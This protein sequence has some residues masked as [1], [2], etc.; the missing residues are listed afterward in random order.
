MKTTI[1]VIPDCPYCHQLKQLLTSANIEYE[2]IDIDTEAGGELF[3]SV[4]EIT[5]SDAV[6]TIVIDDNILVPNV[7]FMS[8]EMA[9][10][11]IQLI[12]NKN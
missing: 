4:Y 3:D 11:V 10:Q 6:P 2:E 5:K 1:Y 12:L 9:L 8:I 7:S